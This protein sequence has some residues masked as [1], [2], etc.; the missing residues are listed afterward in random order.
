MLFHIQQVYLINF[1]QTHCGS[2][3]HRWCWLLNKWIRAKKKKSMKKICFCLKLASDPSLHIPLDQGHLIVTLDFKEMVKFNR[4]TCPRKQ[5][6]LGR[7]RE[8]QWSLT[9]RTRYVQ[10]VETSIAQLRWFKLWINA[11][12]CESYPGD[13]SL[14]ISKRKVY[15]RVMKYSV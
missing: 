12:H 7:V 5:E 2:P 4:S 6:K 10:A 8:H 15:L 13:K 1:I 14:Q 11:I 3:L 9:S